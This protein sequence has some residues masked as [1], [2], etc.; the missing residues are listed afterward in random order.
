MPSRISWLPEEGSRCP[1]R[2]RYA[3]RR[4]GSARDHE[5]TASPLPLAD[6][7]SFP[8]PAAARALQN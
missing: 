6:H 5:G 8:N 1:V 3:Q 7:L 4:S 2:P